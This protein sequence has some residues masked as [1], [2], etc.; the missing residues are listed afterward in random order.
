MP[1]QFFSAE[2]PFIDKEVKK[3]KR[4][5]HTGEGIHKSARYRHFTSH[6]PHDLFPFCTLP[7]WFASNTMKTPV[8]C[9]HLRGGGGGGGESASF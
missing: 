2:E 9:N 6:L 7:L 5:E 8:L 4:G 3:T 1:K